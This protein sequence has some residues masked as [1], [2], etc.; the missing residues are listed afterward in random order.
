M[1][2]SLA[3]APTQSST[4]AD[5]VEGGTITGKLTGPSG[6]VVVGAQV[7][8][9]IQNPP[10]PSSGKSFDAYSDEAGTFTLTNL[11]AGAYDVTV[12]AFGFKLHTIN[13]V[14]VAES[15]TTNLSIPLESQ[16]Y[17]ACGITKDWSSTLKEDDKAEIV[18]QI[19]ERVFVVKDLLGPRFLLDQSKQIVL[20]TEQIKP[21]WISN[22]AQ[23]EFILMDGQKIT[24]KADKTGDFQYLRFSSFKTNGPCVAVTLIR[25]WAVGKNSDHTYFGGGGHIYEFH[26]AGDKWVGKF[27]GGW[28][29]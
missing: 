11:P 9:T 2:V 13:S 20:S 18:R 19:L 28:I 3:I 12:Q 27:A 21:G 25:E 16:I 1:C 17:R 29:S 8:A 22:Y 14:R 5:V 10:T 23:V 24:E 15:K 6:E 26:K 4:L 7:T